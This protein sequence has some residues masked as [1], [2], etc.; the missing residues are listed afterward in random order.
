[1]NHR[2]SP[3]LLAALGIGFGGLV[4]AVAI[5]SALPVVIGAP[6]LVCGL[7]ALAA[8]APTID[9]ITVRTSRAQVLVGD[10]FEV[11]VD[12]S[13]QGLAWIEVRARASGGL[14]EDSASSVIVEPATVA[15]FRFVAERWGGGS[16]V[17]LE[18]RARGR[19][20]FRVIRRDARL[21]RALRV[22]PREERL[23]HVL[24]PHSLRG[25]GGLHPSRQ[26]GEGFEFAESRP[27]VAGDRLRDVNWRVSAR[28]PELWIDRRHPDLSG[29]VVLFLDSFATWGLGRDETLALAVDA[30][31][32]LVRAHIGAQ[33]GVGLVDLGGTLRWL[34]T[35]SGTAH[36]Y[37]LV[38]T[39]VESEVIETFADKD[40]DVIP[41]FALPPRALVIALSPLADQRAL[42]TLLQLRARRF[43]VAVIECAAASPLGP[44]HDRVDDL[45]RR[46]WALEHDTVRGSLR[47]AGATVVTWRQGTAIG[48]LVDAL[49]VERRRPRVV[50]W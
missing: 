28:R 12:V 26:R 16:D 3:Q 7:V 18:V 49:V 6:F 50:G 27:Y 11:G 15:T 44:P 21:P 42:R 1:M 47:R 14:T 4:L 24:A 39:L 13:G 48:P 5:E 9:T 17:A 36:A 2:A 30:A 23:A 40:L 46:L 43:D 8:A 34:P 10:P 19:F 35:G 32:S 37:R 29:E 38:E 45:A 22:Y 33:D 20:G 41:T 31:T 25:V